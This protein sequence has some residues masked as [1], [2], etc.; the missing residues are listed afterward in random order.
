MHLIK[1]NKRINDYGSN[2][3]L[4]NDCGWFKSVLAMHVCI[5]NWLIFIV[6]ACKW[7]MAINLSCKH[8]ATTALTECIIMYKRIKEGAVWNY[9]TW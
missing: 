4:D 9:Y 8:M 3:Y 6:G 7:Q 2:L 1:Y 5:L